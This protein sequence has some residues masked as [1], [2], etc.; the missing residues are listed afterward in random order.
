M[1]NRAG[2]L[3]SLPL[4]RWLPTS[5]VAMTLW[6]LVASIAIGG[7]LSVPMAVARVSSNPLIRGPYGSTP[8]CFAARRC[9]SSC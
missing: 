1:I 6:L 5:G 8:M 4:V 7:L 3:A 2:I 9:I